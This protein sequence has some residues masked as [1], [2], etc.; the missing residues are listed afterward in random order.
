MHTSHA[1]IPLLG[2]TLR[3]VSMIRK[4]YKDSAILQNPIVLASVSI[5]AFFFAVATGL[6][7]GIEAWEKQN[8]LSKYHLRDLSML[9]LVL[10]VAA[11]TSLIRWYWNVRGGT[12]E[13]TG[14]DT[15]GQLFR[16][17]P[18]LQYRNP[19]YIFLQVESAK[20][21]WE[22]SLD[23]IR[24]MVVLS[25]LDGMIH[26]CNRAF[27]EFIGLSFQEIVQANFV[28]LLESRGIEIHGLDLGTLNARINTSGKWY[29]VRAYPYMEFESANITRVVIIMRDVSEGK[30][31]D[32]KVQ[33]VWGHMGHFPMDV[34][35]STSDILK[36]K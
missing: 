1:K 22:R 17:R 9:I 13:S 8:N 4:Q 14:P 30:M 15:G 33:F 32:E 20:R 29:S 6:L 35:S 27:S 26:R 5:L 34:E 16:K 10:A 28:S 24:D 12:V 36:S 7:D 3:M 31:S 25:D 2:K 23:S 21:E 18:A 19:E 11:T